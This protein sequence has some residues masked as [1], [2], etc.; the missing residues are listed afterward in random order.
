MPFEFHFKK[1]D[2]DKYED[3][4][5]YDMVE[6]ERVSIGIRTGLAGMY[7]F[8]MKKLEHSVIVLYH[9]SDEGRVDYATYEPP[10]RKAML[11]RV[12]SYHLALDCW[13]KQVDIN[14]FYNLE[15]E[16]SNYSGDIIEHIDNNIG[17]YSRRLDSRTKTK[18]IVMNSSARGIFSRPEVLGTS[19]F[20]LSFAFN[21][22]LALYL[23]HSDFIPQPWKE[24]IH[25]KVI[26]PLQNEINKVLQEVHEFIEAAKHKPPEPTDI[27]LNYL[28][29]VEVVSLNPTIPIDLINE[30]SK[31]NYDLYDLFDAIQSLYNK[32]IIDGEVFDDGK[33]IKF[34]KIW[35]KV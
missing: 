12:L 33:R 11:Q 18:T 9:F 22:S 32:G 26:F 30:F 19:L 21:Y 35:L 8:L 27:L 3:F 4:T 5:R 13:A 23:F 1:A 24:W 16:L 34:Y 28:K 10:H 29:R 7:K 14:A 15:K 25:D 2:Y 31:Y 6:D 20:S 17:M